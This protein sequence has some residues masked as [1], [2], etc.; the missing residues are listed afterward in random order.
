MW[1]KDEFYPTDNQDGYQH[2]KDVALN[3]LRAQ[4]ELL[5][6]SALFDLL[7]SV[8][9]TQVAIIVNWSTLCPLDFDMTLQE[10][11]DGT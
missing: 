5:V 10:I 7:K 11:D 1:Q 6:R 2:L 8:N 9:A 3:A 4:R